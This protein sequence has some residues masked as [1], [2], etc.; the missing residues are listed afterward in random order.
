MKRVTFFNILAII[1]LPLMLSAQSEITLR[2]ANPTF[3]C[4]GKTY[5]LDVEMS[6]DS[7]GDTL[8]G[9]N[10]RFFYNSAQ[11]DLINFT[12]LATN[13]S[14]SRTPD[15]N[16]GVATSGMDLFNFPAGEA[17]VWVNG[18][19]EL[20]NTNGGQGI[21]VGGWTKFFEVCF[22]VVGDPIGVE[23]FCPEVIWD[24]EVDRNDGGFLAGNDGVVVAL[25]SSGST[26]V[27][28]ESVD[29]FNWDYSGNGTA[30]YGDYTQS[31]G[32]CLTETCVQ[33]NVP[34]T[35]PPVKQP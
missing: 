28:L 10:V 11:L 20:Q 33:C 9:T 7:P 27:A 34:N 5:C 2:F 23:N 6:S 24:L 14:V 32:G 22:D 8:Y 13:Y 16:Q 35:V 17:A 30:P 19:V 3:D 12:N 29:H 1:V 31:A 4:V 25:I 26:D 21:A 15:V 18:A